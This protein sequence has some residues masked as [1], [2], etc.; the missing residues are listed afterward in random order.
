ME[1]GDNLTHAAI[2]A[3]SCAWDIMENQDVPTTFINRS[4]DHEWQDH[5]T[6]LANLFAHVHEQYPEATM[7]WKS[8]AGLH[9][10]ISYQFRNDSIV[11][12]KHMSTYRAW[13]MHQ[14]QQEVVQ[15]AKQNNPGK[16]YFLDVY[17]A[18]Y[19]SADRCLPGDGRHYDRKLNTLVSSWFVNNN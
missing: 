17:P 9:L 8:C 7:L 3:G 13:S 10:H 5:R 12:I 2:I 19:L 16:V 14:A 11:R 6:A 18:F 1:K 4:H 15:Q